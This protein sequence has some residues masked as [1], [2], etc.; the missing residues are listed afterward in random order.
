MVIINFD[1]FFFKCQNSEFPPIINEEQR[2]RY[3]KKFNEDYE[4]YRKLHTY[5]AKVPSR[6]ADL[7][8]RRRRECGNQESREVIR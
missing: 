5:I 2:L 7:E 6:F 4:E 8:I 3:K 1:F